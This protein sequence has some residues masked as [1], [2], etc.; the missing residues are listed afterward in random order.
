MLLLSMSVLQFTH[1]TQ[2]IM[3]NVGVQ[4]QAQVIFPKYA[5]DRP[6]H[7]VHCEAATHV[8]SRQVDVRSISRLEARGCVILGRGQ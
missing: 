8:V 6:L 3:C 4:I 7:E 2:P 1:H 5:Q